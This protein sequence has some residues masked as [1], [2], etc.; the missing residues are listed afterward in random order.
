[1]ESEVPDYHPD[2]FGNPFDPNNLEIAAFIP[3]RS[4]ATVL[5]STPKLIS[6]TIAAAKESK[7][8]KRVF[9]TADSNELINIA[10][11]LGAEAPYLRDPELSD[12]SLRVD[13]VLSVF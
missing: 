9:V 5:D 3:L 4:D 13:K 12:N 7:Y 6:R 10:K 11:D 8:I 1:M 2:K